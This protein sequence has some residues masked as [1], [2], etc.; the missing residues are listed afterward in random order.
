[1][2]ADK[3]AIKSYFDS[4][5]VE[6]EHEERERGL[7]EPFFTGSRSTIKEVAQTKHKTA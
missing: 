6:R 4:V 1:M 7:C 5:G 2:Q 3:A